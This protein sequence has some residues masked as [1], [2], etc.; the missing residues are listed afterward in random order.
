MN[1]K[2]IFMRKIVYSIILLSVLSCNKTR[3]P[4]SFLNSGNETFQ[5]DSYELKDNNIKLVRGQILYMPIYSNMPHYM[6]SA[7][8]D[9]SAFV[10]FHNT[11]FTHKII[12][13]KVQYFD[14]KGKM[15][16]DYLLETK[17]I[18]APLETA[19]FY[20]PYQDQSGTGA[21]FLIEWKSD[22]LVTEP[23]VESVTIN[24]LSHNSVGV[25]STGK[26][27]KELK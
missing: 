11:D 6:D 8:F 5:P 21:N 13:Q 18:L 22:S 12:L 9:M 15:V 4:D 7:K 24:L 10:A 14:T 27:I 26:V 17:K 16:R 3:K 25:L 2:I 20:V 1:T 23:L 19:D